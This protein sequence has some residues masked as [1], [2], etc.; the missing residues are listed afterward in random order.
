MKDDTV[1]EEETMRLK[2]IFISSC[3]TYPTG[4]DASLS[5]LKDSLR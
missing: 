2:T 1:E 4:H 5:A 3:L